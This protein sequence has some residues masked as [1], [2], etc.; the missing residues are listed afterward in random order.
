MKEHKVL[1]VNLDSYANV[2]SSEYTWPF[3]KLLG[4]IGACIV[5]SSFNRI[6][7]NKCCFRR[8]YKF[9][10]FIVLWSEQCKEKIALYSTRCREMALGRF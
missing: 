4:A 1:H 7:K 5:F 8:V 6:F 10:A 9:L 3:Y 2:E